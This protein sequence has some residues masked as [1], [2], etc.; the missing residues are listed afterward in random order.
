MATGASTSDESPSEVYDEAVESEDDSN[1][2]DACG[3]DLETIQ[4]EEDAGDLQPCR[5]LR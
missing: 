4:E 2:N 1:A 5:P 3:D